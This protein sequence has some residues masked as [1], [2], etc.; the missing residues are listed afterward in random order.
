MLLGQS[1]RVQSQVGPGSDTACGV[2]VRAVLVAGDMTDGSHV[3]FTQEMVR[4]VLARPACRTGLVRLHPCVAHD[5]SLGA[6]RDGDAVL[7]AVG[8]RGHGLCGSGVEP[9]ASDKV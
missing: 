7:L 4:R 1:L 6:E 2:Q 3:A 8:A 9:R 5:L